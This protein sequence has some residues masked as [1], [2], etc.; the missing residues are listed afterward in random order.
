MTS[1]R[2]AEVERIYHA[3]L[4]RE[5]GERAAF[6]E[7]ACGGDDTLEREVQ[8][9]LDYV[10]AAGAFLGRPA[11][12]DEV[13]GLLQE[14]AP[15]LGENDIDGYRILSLLGA[16]GMGEVYRAKDLTLGREVA[17]K[18]LRRSAIGG[19]GDLQ[20]FEEEARLASVLNHQNIVTIYGVGQKGDLAYIAMELVRGRTLRELSPRQPASLEGRH[21][22]GRPT[23][24]RA[25]GRA[26]VRDHPSGPEAGEPDGDA[27]RPPQGAG[28]RNREASGLE[29]P[30]AAR[31]GR[32]HRRRKDPRNGRI[33]VPRA[34][35]GQARGA[36]SDQFSFG[37]ILYEMVT[38]KRAWKRDT[39]AETLTAIIRENPRPIATAAPGTPTALRWIIDRCLAKDPEERYASTRDLARDLA[40]LRDHLGEVSGA[41]APGR[42]HRPARS[43]PPRQTCAAHGRRVRRGLRCGHSPWAPDPKTVLPDWIQVGFRRGLVWSARFTPDG[44][45]IVY[46]AIWDGG[47][48]RL[49]STR[50]ASTETRSL[51]L[52]PGKLLAISR[53][54]ELAF[55]RDVY[56]VR[57]FAQPGTL[58][59]AGLEAGAGRDILEH[60]LS[61]DWSRDGKQLAVAR[62]IDE[63]VTLEYPIG[64]KLYESDRPIG[65]VRI[66][67]DGAWIAF[68]EGGWPDAIVEA[69]RVSDGL[70][71][72]LSG[73]WFPSAVGLAWSA[74]GREIWFTPSK[75][76]RDSSP[77]LLAVTLSG[78]LRE[79]VRGPG[80][81]RLFDIATDGRVLLA[82]SD[83]QTGVRGSPPALGQERELS[84][85]DNSILSDLSND[86]RE[87]L[88]YDRNALFLRATDGSPPLR[89][90]EGYESAR[91]SPDGKWIV[92]LSSEAPRNPSSSRSEP[93]TCAASKR[94]SARAWNGSRREIG[95]SVRSPTLR[96]GPSTARDRGRVRKGDRDSD[97]E[98]RGRLRRH[99]VLSPD[100]A[101]LAGLGR[102][103][104]ILILPLAGGEPRRMTAATTGLERE[105]S[106][107]MDRGWRSLFV[108]RGG[109][110]DRGPDARPLDGP[111]SHGDG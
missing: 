95:F 74:D 106:R 97:R 62:E 65:E 98:R 86:G 38:G 32:S 63:K 13:Q 9:L 69:V 45:T 57:F 108:Y 36:A 34:G 28:L 56:L 8:S 78:K 90:G 91:L 80:Q 39:A 48:V 24:R 66:S 101:F 79:V 77:P 61:A 59:R 76:V 49:Y 47:P 35:R 17:L 50:L 96:K 99:G 67:P 20:R 58:V 100:G 103:G 40:T 73:G 10:P 109:C 15:P 3:T 11:L 54:N 30:D 94:P 89:I 23:G 111:P 16:G 5:A 6:L 85:T 107:R 110:S 18:V 70:R 41:G 64:T 4:E 42:K 31:V 55:L 81:L 75:Q 1:E 2:W 44:Q 102:H 84:A 51:D 29:G 93:E 19:P 68:C 83:A 33:H 21:R 82:R 60:V 105:S 12:E 37:T 52:P 53:T 72:V 71:R 104:D 25:F 92:A 43:A 7:Q 27:G 46:S 88:F 26:C 87:V 22:P 14:P